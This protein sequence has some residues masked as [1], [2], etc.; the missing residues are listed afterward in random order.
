MCVC[1]GGVLLFCSLHFG[2]LLSHC[3][4]E[5]SVNSLL[6]LGYCIISIKYGVWCFEPHIYKRN[7]AH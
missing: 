2:L 5:R 1:V 4:V 3:V 6:S 7:S